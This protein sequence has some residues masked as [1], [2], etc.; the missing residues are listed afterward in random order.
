MV[1]KIILMVVISSLIIGCVDPKIP[2]IPKNQIN[3][4]N[5][6]QPS[7]TNIQPIRTPQ[8]NPIYIKPEQKIIISNNIEDLSQ[9][10]KEC[11]KLTTI[12]CDEF[13]NNNI[14]GK[15]VRIT[16]SI[17]DV[18]NNEIIVTF[19][20]TFI[21][22]TI[23]ELDTNKLMKY[24]KGDIITY[25]SRIFLI[26][27]KFYGYNIIE[28]NDVLLEDFTIEQVIPDNKCYGSI[29]ECNNGI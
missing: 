3:P 18:R 20:P 26:R 29:L 23:T 27:N 6:N 21:S 10:L 8:P 7:Q 22:T 24:N 15:Y 5:I 16:G 9:K 1:S 25:T 19:N 12:Q 2:G 13:V 28:S 4:T 14:N 17:I 11:T